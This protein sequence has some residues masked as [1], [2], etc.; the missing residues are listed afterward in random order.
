[1]NSGQQMLTIFGIVILTLLILNVYNSQS[2]KEGILLS[3]EAIITSTGLA[4]SM[5]NEIEAK[6]F[7]EK[8]VQKSVAS[9]D[10]LILP[11]SLGADAGEVISTQFNDVDDYKNYTKK[12]TIKNLGVFNSKVD[13]YYVN[14]LSPGVKSNTQTF[15]KEIVV[16]IFNPSL[17]DTLKFHR[18][19]AY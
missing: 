7:D 10:S 4:Q 12:D 14:K 11:I 15:T 3:N 5:L 2:T 17:P 9:K 6:A 18:I 19:I 13:V 16:S 8:T 1:M